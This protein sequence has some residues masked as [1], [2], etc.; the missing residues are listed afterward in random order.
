MGEAYPIIL[1]IYLALPP[2][3]MMKVFTAFAVFLVMKSVCAK[4][5]EQH[6]DKLNEAQKN[7]LKKFKDCVNDVCKECNTD[8]PNINKIVQ[9]T[10]VFEA[11]E[12]NYMVVLA[13][14]F[15]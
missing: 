6:M 14:A 8:E 13:T 10:F 1:K 9:M 15:P 12:P 2:R 11:D 3:K 4:S 5:L 7:T